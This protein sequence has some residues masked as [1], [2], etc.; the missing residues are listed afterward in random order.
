MAE[1]HTRRIEQAVAPIPGNLSDAYPMLLGP[2]RLETVFT[3]TELLVRVFP[4]EWAVD[5]FEP[6]RTDHEHELAFGYWRKVWQAGGDRALRLSAWRDLVNSAGAG[7][8]KWIADNRKPL[9]PQDEPHR[10]GPDHVILVI[11]DDDPLPAADRPP[12]RTYWTAIYRAAGAKAAVQA[13]DS[14]LQSAVGSTRATRIRARR[15]AGMSQVPPGDVATAQVTVA[16]LDMPQAQAGQTKGS[17]W[18]VAAK[19]RLLPDRFTLLGYAGGQLVVNVTGNAVPDEL[20]VSP[21]PSTP[22]ADQLRAQNG[23]LKVPSALAWLTDFNSAVQAGMGFRIPLTD[24][25]R[26][27][28]DR[29]IAIGVRVKSG[30]TQA[31]AE[32]EGLI[33]RQS[34]SRAGYRLLRQGTP[35]NNT[36]DAQSGHGTGDEAEESYTAVFEGPASPAPPGDWRGKTDGQWLAELL[37]INPEVTRQLIG[38]DGTDTREARAMNT[39]LWPATWGYHLHTM[40]NPVFGTAAVDATRSF[41]TRYVSGRGP[42]ATVQVGRQPYGLLVTTAF[43]RMAWADNDTAAAHRRRMHTVLQTMAGDW[44]QLAAGVPHLG[45]DADP[46][47]LLLDLLAAHPA[48]VEFHQRYGQSAEDYFNRLNLEGFGTDV[49]TALNTLNVRGRVRTLLTH[50]GYDPQRPDPDASTR[51]FT[52][53]QHA[54]RGPIVDDLPMSESRPVH[55][56]SDDGRNYLAWLAHFARADFNAVRREDGFS[57][58][59]PTALLYLL[60]RHA[61]LTAY[62]EAALRLS[63]AA[64]GGNETQLLAA[65]REQPFVHISTRTQVSESRYGRLYAPD[66]AVTGAPD[67]LIADYIPQV[68]GQRPA[69]VDLAEQL[70]AVDLLAQVPTARLER[71]LAEHIDCST[72]RLDAWRLG[73]ATERLFTMRYGAAGSGPATTGLHLGAF[74]WLENLRPRGAFEQVQLSGRLAQVFTPPGSGPL[75][76]DPASGGHIHTPSLNHA[77][78]AALLRTGYLA[79]GG[80]DNPGTMAVNLS[81]ER[82]RIALS[83]IEG[84]RSGQSLGALLGYRFERGLHD[85]H[86]VAEVD[87]FIAALRTA[88]PLVATK[89]PDTEPLAGTAIEQ[90]EARNV[91]DGLE[92]VRHVTRTGPATYPFGHPELPP[93]EPVQAQAIE[94][95]VQRLVEIHDALAD[96][97]V[98]EGVHQAVLGNPDRAGAVFE[99]YTKS[100]FPPE[101]VVTA[102]P[103]SGVSLNHRVGLHVRA[104]RPPK[105]SPVAGGH[106][107]PRGRGEPGVNDWLA[108]LL[109]GHGQVACRV[110]WTDP[111]T[112]DDRDRV[113]NLAELGM[114][115]ID[116]LWAL[117][118]NDA[119]AMTDLDDRILGQVL[120]MGNIRPDAEPL[121]R[122]TERVQGKITFFELSPLISALRQLLLTA[123][124]LRPSDLVPQSGTETTGSA[125]DENVDLPRARPAAVR[126]AMH[127]FAEELDEFIED[128]GEPLADPVEN[129]AELLSDVDDYL[130]RMAELAITAAGFA[131]VRSGWGELAQW[132]RDRFREVLAAVDVVADRMT[133]TLAA[134]DAKIAANDALPA[135]TAAEVRFGLLQ[136]AERLLT[137]TP[138]SPRPQTPQQLRGIVAGRRATFDVRLSGLKSIANT[139]RSTLSGLLHDVSALQPITAFDPEGLDLTPTEDA[140]IAFL[141]GLAARA[142]DLRADV[143]QRLTAADAELARYDAVAAGKDR[144]TAAVAAIRALIGPDALAVHEF[145]VPDD[146]GDGWRDGYLASRRGDLTDHL[147]RDFPVDDWLHGVAR[148]RPRLGVWER[149]TLLTDA[150]DGH[151]PELLPVQFPFEENAPW[152]AMELPASYQLRS[153]RLLYTA[154]YSDQP[155][156]HDTFCALLIDEWTETLPAKAETTGIALH[157]DR[158]GSEPP[159]TMLLVAPPKRTG[160]WNWD[161]LVAALHETLDLA[162]SRAVE[163]TQIDGTAYAQLL[164]ATVMTATASPITIS[165]DLSINN[166]QPPASGPLRPARG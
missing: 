84:I 20:A 77:T 156:P 160:A 135:G 132:R 62:D 2:V 92:L 46:H 29:L 102:T 68:I 18:T 22:S 157:Y 146:L 24:A 25:I 64:H 19:A 48:S 8:A 17:S 148:V 150:L 144:V 82:V 162:R 99:A 119:A 125:L 93:A 11:A 129:R 44:Q 91:I 142:A 54:L 3:P 6:K 163:P 137:T 32:L 31:K 26:G 73:L 52:G 104:G 16:F 95:E 88:F 159:Q 103:R 153:D 155:N 131:M 67:T 15:P 23:D 89:L 126:E 61:V 39:A 97:A 75:L 37:G 5:A 42:L 141:T 45:Q 79:N 164:P 106:M 122:Y 34:Q 152:L 55:V 69:T 143:G 47:Q 43:S 76:R 105:I 12:A 145:T 66:P 154:H 30:P 49:I 108:R 65:R 120:Q 70:D 165:T 38:A 71:A 81:S 114:Q 13:A 158:P 1:P 94:E 27:G 136:Q 127:D 151:E 21:D 133:V 4:D 7:R 85:K 87:F 74:G 51:L 124:P 90:V 118:P 56:S 121:I 113:V 161:D 147:D 63:A 35:T 130:V 134:A 149:V 115:P 78:T 28:L 60:L 58:G 59:K 138:T 112:G 83:F 53:R 86:D 10:I 111:R 107:T 101:P 109:P 9:N 96:L 80:P 140:V 139:N 117:R 50:L 40:L 116:L 14:A 128:L 57:G 72:Y 166:D 123:R 100:G 33:A 36:G 110:T 98:A 41:F